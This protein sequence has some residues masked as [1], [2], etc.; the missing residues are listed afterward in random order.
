MSRIIATEDGETN[1]QT[2]KQTMGG[3][4]AEHLGLDDL[5]IIQTHIAV[6]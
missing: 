6:Q 3:L 4:F 2:N 1:K 5:V